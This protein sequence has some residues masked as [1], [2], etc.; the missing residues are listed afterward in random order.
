MTAQDVTAQDSGLTVTWPV[1]DVGITDT[2]TTQPRGR[3]IHRVVR[4]TE[5]GPSWTY[6]G[7]TSDDPREPN[8]AYIRVHQCGDV[9]V[10]VHRL[11][12]RNDKLYGALSAEDFVALIKR[13]LREGTTDLLVGVPT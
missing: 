6:D 7:E 3:V 2:P 5:L 4:L 8:S 10:S 1:L 11:I 13:Q 9:S 12:Y